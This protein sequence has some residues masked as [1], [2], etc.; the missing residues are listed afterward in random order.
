[1]PTLQI[2]NSNYCW[3]ATLFTLECMIWH[4]SSSWYCSIHSH[5]ST[6]STLW[7]PTRM[8]PLTI[9]HLKRRRI[10]CQLLKFSLRRPMVYPS[11]PSEASPPAVLLW[12]LLV[13]PSSLYIFTRT[14]S[15]SSIS[16]CPRFREWMMPK[17]SHKWI[18]LEQLTTQR[19]TAPHRLLL[20]LLKISISLK[21]NW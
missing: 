17:R 19:L 5:W 8:M 6:F 7:T 4:Q 16:S 10:R 11:V 20:S 1:M 9:A 15:T 18:F 2:S 21:A 14:A 12:A 3:M 13:S